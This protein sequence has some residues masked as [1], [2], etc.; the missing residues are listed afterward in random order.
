MIH[1]KRDRMGTHQEVV[2]VNAR[3]AGHQ[4]GTLYLGGDAML[5]HQLGFKDWKDRVGVNQRREDPLPWLRDAWTHEGPLPHQVYQGEDGRDPLP[6]QE[7]VGE[8]WVCIIISSSITAC[9]GSRSPPERVFFV[10][11]LVFPPNLSLCCLSQ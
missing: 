11:V 5:R 1:S 8:K 6:H 4:G 3:P 9:L 7:S 2:R 10:Q